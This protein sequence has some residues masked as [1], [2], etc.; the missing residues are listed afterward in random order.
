MSAPS[1]APPR[2]P[3]HRLA[4][5]IAGRRTKWAVLA[6]WIVL[7]MAL[8]PLA[9]KLGDVEENDA[10][11]WLPAGAESTQVVELEEQ[12]RKDETMPA[13]IVYERSGG[14]TTADRAKAAAD[15]GALQKLPGAQK[16]AG[17]FPSQDGKALQTLVP[18]T[19]VDITAASTR[20]VPSPNAGLRG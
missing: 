10:A 16:V 13:V 14:I 3:S 12:F 1:P 7:L 8:G 2:P 20:R 11:A 9:G 6:L 18:L 15:V 19:D 17:P 4:G 5:L